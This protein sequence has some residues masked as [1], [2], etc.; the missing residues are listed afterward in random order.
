MP[1]KILLPAYLR[2]TLYRKN[3][4][5]RGIREL[6]QDL[7][8]EILSGR[9]TVLVFSSGKVFPAQVIKAV[10]K[11]A[12]IRFT[13][14]VPPVKPPENILLVVSSPTTRYVF[15]ALVRAVEKG[16]FQVQFL[17]PRVE[18]RL[19]PPGERAV[20]FTPLP[21]SL[22]EPLLSGRYFLLRDTNLSP[23]GV[24]DLEQGY[25]YDLII[26][27]TDNVV[28][29]FER[30]MSSPGKIF[31]LR[32]ISRGGACIYM[33]RVFSPEKEAFPLYLRG[34]LEGRGRTFN[35]GL[36]GITRRVRI[37]GNRTYFHIMWV[38]RLRPFIFE[39]I[40]GLFSE[41]PPS[42]DAR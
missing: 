28:G 34:T 39:F 26:D 9:K 32:D 38:Q 31:T 5:V 33:N 30:L 16:I 23:E 4:Q 22:F 17:E 18:E 21:L 25:V 40:L 14:P 2:E 11:A 6:P 1:E 37:E 20:F 35:F 12:L 8:D 19:V 36:L 10:D 15:Q 41:T 3:I 13:G 27:D 29:E 7:R 24:R 42:P